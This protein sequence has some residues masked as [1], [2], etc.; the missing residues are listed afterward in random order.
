MESRNKLRRNI[1]AFVVTFGAA[2][3]NSQ[4]LVASDSYFI[5][6]GL[7]DEFSLER[8]N[9]WEVY[10]GE[11]LVKIMEHRELKLKETVGFCSQSSGQTY[12]WR[13][14]ISLHSVLLESNHELDFLCEAFDSVAPAAENCKDSELGNFERQG[15]LVEI[16]SPDESEVMYPEIQTYYRTADSQ[17][18][19]E[20]RELVS[21]YGRSIVGPSFKCALE[22]LTPAGTGMIGIEGVCSVNGKLSKGMLSMDLGNF[23]DHFE[24]ALPDEEEWISL[25]PCTPV[26]GLN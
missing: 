7:N 23:D 9:G 17:C 15:D 4:Q 11:T 12:P 18:T 1:L 16:Y 24:L 19:D 5:C 22:A 6:S 25:Y 3:G 10:Q 2:L 20:R 8:E 26:E 14:T 21:I 13:L